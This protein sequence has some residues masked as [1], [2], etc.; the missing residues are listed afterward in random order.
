MSIYTY[1]KGKN[2]KYFNKTLLLVL[3]LF[4]LAFAAKAHGPKEYNKSSSKVD[5]TLFKQRLESNQVDKNDVIIQAMMLRCSGQNSKEH[6]EGNSDGHHADD[7]ETSDIEKSSGDVQ[8][9]ND[10]KNIDT[11]NEHKKPI[12]FGNN[13]EENQLKMPN[14]HH[15]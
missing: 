7:T 9:K 8:V 10:V 6:D 5:C 14:D 4:S 15:E 11:Q 12:K 1:S 3:V 2:M 13:I